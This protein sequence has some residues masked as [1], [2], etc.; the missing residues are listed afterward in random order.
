MRLFSLPL[1]ISGIALGLPMDMAV[2]QETEDTETLSDVT[3]TAT[4]VEKSSLKVPQAVSTVSKD[5]IQLGRQQLGLD[6]SML[7]IPGVFFQDRYNFS[8]DLRISIRGFGA[9][10]NFG[11]VSSSH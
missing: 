8:Q 5:D 10:S 4:R 11:K 2:S 3:V 1:V 6:E 7:N 9:R